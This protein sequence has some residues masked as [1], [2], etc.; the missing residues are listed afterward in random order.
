MSDAL[1]T[2]E[3]AAELLVTHGIHLTSRTLSRYC[4]TGKF[5]SAQHS[6]PV[7]VIEQADLLRFATEYPRMRAAECEAQRQRMARARK[8]WRR[9]G[10]R[11]CQRCE[12]AENVGP[13]ALCPLCRKELAG[14]YRWYPPATARPGVYTCNWEAAR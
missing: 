3:M 1:F 11:R 4:L 9:R 10:P 8:Y 14:N 6:G 7:W 2:T 5:P 13:D 12:I